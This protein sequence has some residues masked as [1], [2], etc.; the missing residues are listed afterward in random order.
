VSGRSPSPW[1][2]VVI[3]GAIAVLASAMTPVYGAAPLKKPPFAKQWKQ[4][5]TKRLGNIGAAVRACYRS[6]GRSARCCG[7]EG[8]RRRDAEM[9]VRP[10]RGR[11]VSAV[12][13]LINGNLQGIAELCGR[14]RA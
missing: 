7:P 6:N 1:R 13:S 11:Q 5:R 3:S 10:V 8:L 4:E 9:E 14:K 12:D 2:V